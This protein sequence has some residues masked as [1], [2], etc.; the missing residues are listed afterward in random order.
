ML[1]L[2]FVPLSKGRVYERLGIH[3]GQKFW[4]PFENYISFLGG[5]S[6]DTYSSLFFW[7]TLLNHPERGCFTQKHMGVVSS[8]V[9]D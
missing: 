8:L 2:I 9:I 6:F 3:G 1:I 5:W 4:P 7:H